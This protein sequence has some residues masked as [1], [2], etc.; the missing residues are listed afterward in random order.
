VTIAKRPSEWD[1]MANPII[2]IWGSEKQKYFCK[3]GWTGKPPRCALICPSGK[4]SP[5]MEQ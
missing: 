2:L 1:G 3:G 5:G 4:I